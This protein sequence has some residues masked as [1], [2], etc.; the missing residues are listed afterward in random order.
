MSGA[1]GWMM[2]RGCKLTYVGGTSD[3]R[4]VR[5]SGG[6]SRSLKG[7]WVWFA[8]K[9]IS[10][11]ILGGGR[12]VVGWSKICSWWVGDCVGGWWLVVGG[13]RLENEVGV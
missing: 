7:C 10:V 2:V 3:S 13:W 11:D 6:N 9:G 1:D 5:S 12:W 8:V 4:S